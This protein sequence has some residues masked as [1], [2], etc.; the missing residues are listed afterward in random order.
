LSLSACGRSVAKASSQDAL[1]PYHYGRL[2]GLPPADPAGEHLG[3]PQTEELLIVGGEDHKTGQADDAEDRYRRLEAWTR[4]RFPVQG[5]VRC[6]WS[7]Q[8]LNTIDGLAFIGRNPIDA[9]NVFVATGDC[10]M[11]MTHGTIAGILLTDLIVGRK[12]PWATLY[13]PGRKTLRAAGTFLRESLNV[14]R[15]YGHG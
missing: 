10:G 4:E 13:D 1:D 14:A 8:V 12:N 6:R 9:A 2:Q 11:G 15:Q 7:G 5:A 3:D